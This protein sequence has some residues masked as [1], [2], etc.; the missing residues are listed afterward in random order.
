MSL[1][2]QNREVTTFLQR[3]FF[4]QKFFRHWRLQQLK[5]QAL[6]SHQL[7]TVE[8]FCFCF[9]SFQKRKLKHAL[10]HWHRQC[11]NITLAER[12]LARF[13]IDKTQARYRQ[14]IRKW[15]RTITYDDHLIRINSAC[16]RAAH[17]Q[18]KTQLF[19]AWRQRTVRLRTTRIGK[20]VMY[21]NQMEKF[22]VDTKRKK[23]KVQLVLWHAQEEKRFVLASCFWQMKIIL[24][25]ERNHNGRELLATDIDPAIERSQ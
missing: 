23:G 4:I 14:A 2:R 17:L 11:S 1:V 9:K 21:W 8:R 5:A 3:A 6:A 24:R 18:Y 12:K 10:V 15:Q 20:L 7:Q 19:H 22:R 25:Q 16:T 13:M